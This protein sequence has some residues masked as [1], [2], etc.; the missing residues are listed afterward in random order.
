M[1]L[2]NHDQ[3]LKHQITTTKVT[4]T[5][6]VA[7]FSA[8][9]FLIASLFIYSMKEVT[10]LIRKLTMVNMLGSDVIDHYVQG[11]QNGDEP[12]DIPCLLLEGL[13]QE[14]R[15]IQEGHH[16][17][18]KHHHHHH[19]HHHH[20]GTIYSQSASMFSIIIEDFQKCDNYHVHTACNRLQW[21][22]GLQ[23][24]DHLTDQHLKVSKRG[25]RNILTKYAMTL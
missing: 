6:K 7:V 3:H 21:H 1:K 9:V 18:H 19:H 8:W 14:G 24:G 25:S 23:Q 12:E 13:V 15:L 5:W 4:F 10:N 17:S 2:K 22:F 16:S 20:K 11:D